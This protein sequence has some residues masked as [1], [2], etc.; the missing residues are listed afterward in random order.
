MT[1][2]D[3]RQIR[4]LRRTILLS[5]TESGQQ[6]DAAR[7]RVRAYIAI[8]HNPP[9]ALVTRPCDSQRRLHPRYARRLVCWVRFHTA[10]ARSGPTAKLPRAAAHRRSCG[11]QG[12]IGAARN[13]SLNVLSKRCAERVSGIGRHTP[14]RWH[15]LYGSSSAHRDCTRFPPSSLRGSRRS[16][17]VISK[18]Q[19]WRSTPGIQ[20]MCRDCDAPMQL[21]YVCDACDVDDTMASVTSD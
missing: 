7:G 8:T 9:P 6:G 11:C 13:R 1:E 19:Q 14:Y 21:G 5:I 17:G 20:A 4:N 10:S 16:N 15:T 2:R 12:D 18:Q 3:R